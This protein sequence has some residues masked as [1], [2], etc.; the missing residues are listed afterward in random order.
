[1]CDERLSLN[2]SFRSL[3]FIFVTTNLYSDKLLKS[4]CSP[5]FEFHF[6]K[7]SRFGRREMTRYTVPQQPVQFGRFFENLELFQIL[8]LV[9][10]SYLGIHEIRSLARFQCFAA[11]PGIIH[12]PCRVVIPKINFVYRGNCSTKGGRTTLARS[13]FDHGFRDHK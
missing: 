6:P 3:A 11:R 1:M 9:M 7:V 2:R 13:D 4:F 8:T 5:V 12:M 10:G